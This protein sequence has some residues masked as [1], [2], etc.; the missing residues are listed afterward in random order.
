MKLL[1]LLALLCAL[2]CHAERLLFILAGQSNAAGIGE[3]PPPVYR[4][5]TRVFVYRNSGDWTPGFEP[6]DEPNNQVD[7]VS[8]DERYGVGIGMAFAERYLDLH[9]DVEEVGLIPC[10][11]GGSTLARWQA[12]WSRES[13]YGSCLARA[14]EASA[15]GRLAGMLWWQGEDES[16]TTALTW[17]REFSRFVREFRSDVGVPDLTVVYARIRGATSTTAVVR[18]QQESLSGRAAYRV[19]TDGITYPDGWHPDT[20]GYQ[21][22]GRRMAEVMP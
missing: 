2:P 7:V 15:E 8:R 22:V 21:V 5:A 3:E 17:G 16:A 9:P 12:H 1:A 11:K 20:N 18:A 19:S 14:L 10:A 4:N 13:L 6:V